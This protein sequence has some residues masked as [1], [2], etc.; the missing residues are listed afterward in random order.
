LHGHSYRITL[1]VQG[2]I[3]PQTG[4]LMDFADIHSAFEPLFA[5]LD[6][7]YLNEVEGL[8]N[9]TSENLAHWIWERLKDHLPIFEIRIA[10]TCASACHYRGPSEGTPR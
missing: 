3:D 5:Q 8:E 7:H 2:E 1:V 10:E 9:P 4:W 6:H